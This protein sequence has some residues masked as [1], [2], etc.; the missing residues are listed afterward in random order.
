MKKIFCPDC[1]KKVFVEKDYCHIHKNC[2]EYAFI[3]SICGSLNVDYEAR[4]FNE[5]E[6]LEK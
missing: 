6:I 4:Q 2:E 3:C 5:V 1:N